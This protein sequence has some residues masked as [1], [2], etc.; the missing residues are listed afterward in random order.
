MKVDITGDVM[1]DPRAPAAADGCPCHSLTTR[2]YLDEVTVPALRRGRVAAGRDETDLGLDQ[3][4]LGLGLAP[5]L[6]IGRDQADRM[7]FDTPYPVDPPVWHELLSGLR[8]A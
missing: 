7:S 5:F 6:V 4:D 1:A 3:T 8:A 2:R